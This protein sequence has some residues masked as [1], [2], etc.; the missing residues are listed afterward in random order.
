MEGYVV[1]SATDTRGANYNALLYCKTNIGGYFFDGFINVNHA[2]EL[3]ITEN[4]VETGASVVDHAYVMPSTVTMQ[5]SMSDVHQSYYKG[6]FTGGYSRSVNAWNVLKQIQSDRIPVSVLTRLG[7][8]E[9]MLIQSLSAEDDYKTYRALK[10]TVVLKE[11]PVARVRTVKL[12]SAD[13]TTI[14]T[15][16]GKLE[17]E[18][19]SQEL[20][21]ILYQWFGGES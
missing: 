19:V 17:A 18:E 11:I 7:I 1:K 4:P 20:M 6:Q 9:N 2:R 16:M 12:S 8:Y 13:Q 5:I 15:E 10:A 3:K 14:N 21:S